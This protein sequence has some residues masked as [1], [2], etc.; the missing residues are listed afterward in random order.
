[1]FSGEN[2]LHLTEYE[3]MDK[4][5]RTAEGEGVKHPALNPLVHIMIS[6]ST[7]SFPRLMRRSK[8][9]V[10]VSIPV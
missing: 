4:I 7:R 5:L 8:I 6:I 2:V 1:M 9:H 10:P 3:Y